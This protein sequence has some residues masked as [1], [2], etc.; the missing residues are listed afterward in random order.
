MSG[1]K[2]LFQLD[3]TAAAGHRKMPPAYKARVL[4]KIAVAALLDVLYKC[5]LQV[6]E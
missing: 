3:F 2:R 6:R 1:M 4:D 5:Q